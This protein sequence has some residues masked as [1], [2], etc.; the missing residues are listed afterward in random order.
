MSKYSVS[1]SCLLVVLATVFPASSAADYYDI[2]GQT[3]QRDSGLVGNDEV[4][5][6]IQDI[7]Y[8]GE[9]NENP[10]YNDW[11]PEPIII[12][13]DDKWPLDGRAILHAGQVAGLATCPTG[14]LH[15]FH[16]ASNIWDS[17]SFYSNETYKHVAKGPITNDTVLVLDSTNGT[18]VTSWG[19][20]RFYMPHGI[21]ID[22]EGNIWLTDVALHQVFRFRHD[23]LNEPNL[24][25]GE[26]FVPGNDFGHFCKPTD[27]AVSSTGMVYISDG[28]CNSRIVIADASGRV[29]GQIGINEQMSVPHSLALLEKDDLICVADRENKRILCYTAG[30]G[31]TEPGKLVFNV[32]HPDIGRVFAI[33]HIGDVML[34]INGPSAAGDAPAAGVTLDLATEKLVNMWSPKTGFVDPHDISVSPDQRSFFVCDIG[35]K[36]AQKVYKFNVVA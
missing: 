32:V 5:A 22:V 8:E 3:V 15:L 10:V 1:I 20:N 6:K 2:D 11:K 4:L 21:S 23:D 27:I 9:A 28:Y 7:L 16:R 30:L 29:L 31:D 12:G 36:A 25:L 24:V 13:Q 18:L 14:K 19:K 34:A 33:D 35:P 17:D 26:P